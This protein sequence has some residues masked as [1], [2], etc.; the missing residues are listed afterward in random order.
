MSLRNAQA[1]LRV[2]AVAKQQKLHG[3]KVAPAALLM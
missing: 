3:A 1:Q 2:C